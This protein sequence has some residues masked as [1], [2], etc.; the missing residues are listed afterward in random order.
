MRLLPLTLLLAF[1]S[2]CSPAPVGGS[3]LLG[4]ERLAFVPAG[5]AAA[6]MPEAGAYEDLLV[7]RFEVTRGLWSRVRSEHR[8]LPSLDGRVGQDWDREGTQHLPAAG[9]D[10]SEARAFAAA[11]GMRLPTAK[12]WLYI[13]AGSRGQFY[14]WGLRFDD[15][16]ANTLETGL[17]RGAAAGSFPLGITEH[18]VHDLSGNLWEWIDGEL[19]R[20]WRARVPEGGAVVPHGQWAMGGSFLFHAAQLY[21][22]VGGTVQAL[23]LESRSRSSDLGLRCVAP[24]E[25]YLRVH[26]SEWS[27]DSMKERVVACGRAWGARSTRLLARL[28]EEPGAPIALTWLLQGSRQ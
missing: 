6:G 4:C 28:V 27:D 16:A 25:D 2:G 13:A 23:G 14:P 20:G 8:S 10:H 19:P 1:G 17:G 3:E 22:G 18:G 24:A 26:A 9:M 5:S 11:R 15:R 7:D 12:E 21:D